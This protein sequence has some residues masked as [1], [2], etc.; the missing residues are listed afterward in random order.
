MIP[1]MLIKFLVLRIGG[2]QSKPV[3]AGAVFAGALLLPW[4]KW[5][6]E[7]NPGYRFP[8]QFADIVFIAPCR[9]F[10]L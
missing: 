2:Q 5:E 1:A 8:G 9:S 4:G 6:H 7:F 10:T 3:V